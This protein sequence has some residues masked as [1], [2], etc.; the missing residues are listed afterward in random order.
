MFYKCSINGYFS[1]L[2]QQHTVWRQTSIKCLQT[3]LKDPTVF[4]FNFL[5]WSVAIIDG[6]GSTEGKAS[7]M[8][9]VLEMNSTHNTSNKQIQLLSFAHFFPLQENHPHGLSSTDESLFWNSCLGLLMT[10]LG[11][12]LQ[13][14]VRHRKSSHM[15][16]PSP[17]PVTLSHSAH[18]PQW[19]FNSQSRS[20]FLTLP[21]EWWRLLGVILSPDLTEQIHRCTELL[22]SY[23]L[24]CLTFHKELRIGTFFIN[25]EQFKT[26]WKEQLDSR[27]LI[28]TDVF[29]FSWTDL[30]FVVYCCHSLERSFTTNDRYIWVTSQ[31][32]VSINRQPCK[33]MIVCMF[34]IF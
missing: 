12:C 30:S 31:Y 11:C 33:V 17:G 8:N 18:R 4:G 6:T 14:A 32:W 10:S 7:E 34:E 26:F 27:H 16:Y 1:A 19:H 15:R 20:H 9:E 24:P 3:F 28:T 25:S 22:L 13:H 21:G 29:T 5:K 2:H 23:S